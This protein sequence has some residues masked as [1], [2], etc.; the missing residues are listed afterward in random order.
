MMEECKDTSN[1]KYQ[2]GS[3]QH[4]EGK[5]KVVLKNKS[6]SSK[7]LGIKST[8]NLKSSKSHLHLSFC[9]GDKSGQFK[10]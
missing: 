9:S 3:R 7:G 2:Q 1:K 6:K 10:N 5:G 8:K 4:F